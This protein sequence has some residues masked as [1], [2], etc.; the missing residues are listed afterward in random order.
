MPHAAT[1]LAGAPLAQLHLVDALLTLRAADAKLALAQEG[2]MEPHE[3][4]R[5]R[6]PECH[7]DAFALPVA[8]GEDL[9]LIHI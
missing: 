2:R 6:V 7:E 5:R 4:T 3:R 8:Q 9:S 1:Q